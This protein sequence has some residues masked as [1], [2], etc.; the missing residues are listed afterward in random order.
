MRFFELSPALLYYSC[1]RLPT[2]SI[3]IRACVVLL[4]IMGSYNF[5]CSR[6]FPLSLDCGLHHFEIEI[7][8]IKTLH[9]A[10]NTKTCRC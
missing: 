3:L 6:S 4:L 8:A 5:Y 2:E 7:S 9:A 10:D 1:T